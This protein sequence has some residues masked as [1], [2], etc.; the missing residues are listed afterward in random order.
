M[1]VIFAML[2]RPAAPSGVAEQHPTPRIPAC[3]EGLPRPTA[4][5][6]RERTRRARGA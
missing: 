3:K 1:I 4:L 6:P 2:R 5:N